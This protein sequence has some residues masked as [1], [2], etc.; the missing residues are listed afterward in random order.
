MAIPD[1]NFPENT[2]RV[3]SIARVVEQ[4]TS[5]LDDVRQQIVEQLSNITPLP[6]PEVPGPADR[7]ARLSASTDLLTGPVLA[8]LIA[9][10][11]LMFPYTPT[12]IFG[13][14]ANYDDYHFTHSN[15]RYYQ[16]QASTPSEIQVNGEFT[17]MT[18]D[19]ARYSLGAIRFLQSMTLSEFGK[20]ADS[21]RG[22]PPPVLR[23]NYLG[24]QIFSNVPVV[25]TQFTINFEPDVDYVP[26]R[27]F[28]THVPIKMLVTANLV[29]QP[30]PKRVINEFS[31]KAFKSGELVKKGY[32]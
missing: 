19:E 18:D 24:E 30:N 9:T 16:F 28:N 27:G 6:K 26:V 21:N 14:A 32:I 20:N 15:Y 4:D 3:T 25:I 13:R 2:D 12:V 23:F 8:P 10:G 11:G 22:V 17:A 7:R 1:T 29:V 31:V 5:V